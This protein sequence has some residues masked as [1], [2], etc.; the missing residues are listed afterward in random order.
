MSRQRVSSIWIA[1][2]LTLAACGGSIEAD[3][4]RDGRPGAA[5]TVAAPAAPAAANAGSGAINTARPSDNVAVDCNTNPRAPRRIW[6]LTP[7]QYDNTLKD[8]FGTE[9]KFGAGFPADDIG[10]GF[11][12]AADALLMTPLLADKLQSAADDTAMTADLSRF[13]PCAGSAKDDNCLRELVTRFG[14]R[15]FRRPLSAA[16]IERY[17]TLAKAPGAFDTGARLVVSAMLQSP[18]FLY[19]FEMGQPSKRD[20]AVYELDDYEIAS[21]LSYMLWQTM[22]D[23]ALL[24]AAKS[25][26]LRA[27]AQLAMQVDRMLKSERARPVVRDFVFDWLGLTTIAT[28]PKDTVRYPELTAEIR[29]AMVQ[30]AEQF[31]DHVMFSGGPDGD[32]SIAALLN[33]KTTYL[34]AALSKFYGVA[35][36]APGAGVTLEAQQRRGVLT[37][38]GMMLTHS[39]SNDSSPI[40]R[41]KLIRERLLCQP[42]PPPPP[43][44]MLQPP[45][46]DPSKTARERYADHSS[47]AY[48]SGCH[49][50]MDPIGLAFEHFDGIGRYRTDD[51][52]LPI[53][54]SGMIL[55]NE[56]QKNAASDADGSFMGTDGL[57]DKLDASADVQRCYALSWFRYAYGEGKTERDGVAFPSCQAKQFQTAAVATGG[58]L[59]GIVHALTQAD[60]FTTRAAPPPGS[61][62]TREEAEPVVP[63]PTATMATGPAAASGMSAV[64]NVP[65]ELQV[66]RTVENDWG[67]GYCYTYQLKNTGSAPITWSVPLEVRGKMNNHWECN[68]SGE[69]GSVV[70]TGADHNKTIPPGGMAQFGFCG[71]TS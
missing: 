50:L 56:N 51:N 23:D 43:G 46:L 36:A 63:P 27:P 57:I 39:R 30:E 66:Q 48:C 68:A 41:G 1:A 15:A 10:T 17:T 24:T 44:L 54:V 25:G 5:G 26:Q 18:Y 64:A 21:E 62:V 13:A 9:S 12:N 8:L 3:P 65:P 32:G 60:W 22:P 71:V 33:N 7:Q 31:V 2:S 4:Y 40:H 42:L 28:V 52:G 20:P 29:T 53:D 67:M 14:E 37:L 6:R 70:F 19:R 49:K 55:P 61:V 47:V 69:T 38:G 58:S 16:E 45:G 34:N 11:S 59:S 35:G